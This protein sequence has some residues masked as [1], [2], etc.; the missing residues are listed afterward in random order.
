LRFRPTTYKEWTDDAQASVTEVVIR[1][2]KEVEITWLWDDVK[3]DGKATSADGHEY[4]GTYA[5]SDDTGKFDFKLYKLTTG[6]RL[7]L[8]RWYSEVNGDER[9]FLLVAEPSAD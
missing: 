7:L 1:G 9:E 4:Q 8:G 2:T 5:G 3:Y 6:E